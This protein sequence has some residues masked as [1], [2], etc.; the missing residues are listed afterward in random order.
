M[1]RALAVVFLLIYHVGFYLTDRLPANLSVI[2]RIAGSLSLP[3]FLS[4]LADGF[5]R[6]RNTVS[7]LL[8]LFITAV[9][10]Q[11]LIFFLSPY[12]FLVRGV[13]PLNSLFTLVYGLL[14]MLGA[15]FIIQSVPR[16]RI[17]SLRL[18]AADVH[19]QSDR[20][21]V[22]IGCGHTSLLPPQG[23]SPL[24]I[25][26]SAALPI[27]LI[28]TAGAVTLTVLIPTEA[29]LFGLLN[30]V[31][32]Y[33]A[34]RLNLRRLRL[35]ILLSIYLLLCAAYTVPV[36]LMTGEIPPDW[37]AFAVVPICLLPEHTHPPKK[38][39]RY[40]LYAWYPLQ[41]LLLLLIRKG[42]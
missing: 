12:C 26:C 39:I 13:L 15:E 41:I 1:K 6:T 20:F 7:Y 11:A 5:F 23:L 2:F 30:A 10:S 37:V 21:D 19:N 42:F 8:R 17:G 22:R 3:L 38:V 18:L 25:P 24:H 27:G 29:G 33:A 31:F 28:L 4:L 16:D 40:A 34:H 9:I 14:L 36:M 35:P 32:F